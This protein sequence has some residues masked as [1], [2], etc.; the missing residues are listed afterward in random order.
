MDDPSQLRAVLD[1]L[2]VEF[3]HR[4]DRGPVDTVADLFAPDGWYGWGLD[5]RSTGRESIR[6]AYR[7][8]AAATGVRTARHLMT[9][10]RLNQI[11]TT[12]WAGL[13]IMTIFAENGP[14]PHPAVPL[15]ICD[16][17]DVFVLHEGRWLFESRQLTDLFADPNRT[18]VLPLAARENT[19]P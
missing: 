16:V 17:D 2:I 15:L 11:D 14:P 5:K 1:Q 9:N 10:I 7:A 13:S 19:A 8:R 6:A 3:A 18:A 12:H 4:V